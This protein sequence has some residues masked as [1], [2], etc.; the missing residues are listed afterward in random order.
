MVPS[1]GVSLGSHGNSKS[2]TVQP[3]RKRIGLANGPRFLSKDQEG[4]LKRLFGIMFATQHM[5]AYA[6][7]DGGM[8]LQ[9]RLEHVWFAMPDEALQELGVA[10]REGFAGR[11]QSPNMPQDRS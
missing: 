8:S 7:N 1:C 11:R 3:A 2:S 4:G 5:K 10:L 6:P 9:K